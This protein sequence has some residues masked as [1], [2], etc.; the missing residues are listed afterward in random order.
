MKATLDRLLKKQYADP[1]S[2]LPPT[3]T[4]L[5][6]VPENTPNLV[7]NEEPQV[8]TI[9]GDP[10]P[11]N[12]YHLPGAVYKLVLQDSPEFTGYP[13]VVPEVVLPQVTNS[14]P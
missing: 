13:T 9:V 5:P 4:K 3:Q 10:V 1:P 2:S 11:I 8:E 12:L 7:S 6:G 14:A